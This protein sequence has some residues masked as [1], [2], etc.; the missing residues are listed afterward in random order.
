MWPGHHWEPGTQGHFQVQQVGSL[1]AGI[2]LPL[3]VLGDVLT[4][5]EAAQILEEA[6]SWLRMLHD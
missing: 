5:A 4:S 1:Y 3:G 2:E 6:R